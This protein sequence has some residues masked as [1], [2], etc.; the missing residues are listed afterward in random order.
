MESRSGVY[1]LTLRSSPRPGF[2]LVAPL[3]I[4]LAT[5]PSSGARVLLTQDEA[6]RLVFP[7]GTKVDRKTTFLKP[8][9]L[10]RAKALA[11]VPITSSLVTSFVG[12]KDGREV[13]TVYCDTHVVRT[14]PESILVLVDPAGAAARI[15]V[16]SF[17]EP[18]DYLP[19][20]HW[21]EQ[22]GG[23]K[24]DD[25]LSLKRAIRPVTGATLTAK[26]T[27]EAA[28]RVLALHAVVKAQAPPPAVSAAPA[29]KP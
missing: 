17:S 3:A 27:T 7:A 12:T 18:D 15:E 24:L 9:E 28:R 6:I 20:A 4:L 29:G 16:L 13:G 19:R 5:A 10:E 22:F 8:A 2:L 23:K 21:Y 11:G 25:E 1:F 26:A 14:L